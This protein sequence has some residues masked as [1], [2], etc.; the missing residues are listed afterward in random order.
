[1]KFIKMECPYCGAR[2]DVEEG[3]KS[4]VC[5]YCGK[6]VMVDDEKKENVVTIK[7]EAKIKDADLLKEKYENERRDKEKEEKK[8]FTRTKGGKFLIVLII[9]ALLGAWISFSGHH[10]IS[11]VIALLQVALLAV[12]L[13]IGNGSIEK[14]RGKKIPHLV[15]VL[16]ACVLVIPFFQFSD[17]KAKT[18]KEK[19]VWPSTELAA[20]LPKPD[21]KYGE[22]QVSTDDHLSV[23][24]DG[25][26]VQDYQKYLEKC[27][28]AGFTVDAENQ[29]DL[30]RAADQDGYVLLLMSEEDSMSIS[31]DAPEEY[32]NIVWPVSAL[33]SSLPAPPVSKAAIITNSA[34]KLT[35]MIPDMDSDA[36]SAYGS[37][38]LEAGFNVDYSSHD[39]YFSGSNADGIK[40]IL[41][42]QT[43][44]IMQMNVSAQHTQAAATSTPAPAVETTP[45]PAPAE[46]AA[47][48]S[49]SGVRPEV[50]DFVD[51]YEN[52]MNSYVDFMKSY[53]ASDFTMLDQYTQIMKQYMDWE[54]KA[55]NVD[56]S[57]WNN[58]ET[59]YY[60]DAQNRINKRLLEIS[61]Q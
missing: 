15:F 2:L 7:D 12:G 19:L 34:D 38:V 24:V 51:G 18:S 1:M 22:V 6:E 26:D 50:K 60:L 30:Y 46:T 47:P 13:M 36:I 33:V 9:L 49:S 17:A 10:V 52:F 55:E 43:G 48:A 3:K 14:I 4:V 27:K 40:V 41:T 57:G 59:A 28:D 53:D 31:L 35:L 39:D 58:D 45:T 8:K 54:N 37:Q 5:Q 29:T 20:R 23:D 32:K 42:K 61:N 25:Y 11:G 16:L 21:A 44:N 56:E